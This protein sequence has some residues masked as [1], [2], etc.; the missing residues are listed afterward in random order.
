M[1][2]WYCA[3]FSGLWWIFLLMFILWMVM[4][5]FI[6]R[7]F[8]GGR[9]PCGCMHRMTDRAE[10]SSPSGRERQPPGSARE[11]GNSMKNIIESM[12]NR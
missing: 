12:A 3:P 10:D 6:M 7:A 9:F 11:E 2:Y 4:M 8:L 5:F 1:W